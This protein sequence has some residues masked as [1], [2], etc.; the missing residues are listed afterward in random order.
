M[1]LLLLVTGTT[2]TNA[3]TFHRTSI[4]TYPRN[5]YRRSSIDRGWDND[6]YL[7]ALSSSSN[8]EETLDSANAKYQLESQSRAKARQKKFQTA[9][10]SRLDSSGDPLPVEWG[11][12][13]EAELPKR[14]PNEEGGEEA[15]GQGGQMF[16]NLLE[17]AEAA[18]AQ[19]VPTPAVPA[20]SATTAAVPET[21]Q[22]A[23]DQMAYYQLQLQAWQQQVATYTEFIAANPAAA[24]T[25]TMPPPPPPPPG[26]PATTAATPTTTTTTTPPAVPGTSAVPP[27]PTDPSQIKDP[28][29]Y[30]MKNPNRNSDAYEIANTSDVYLAQLKRDTAVRTEARA[31]GDNNTANQPF[32]ELGVKAIRGIISDEL[33]EVR[34]KQ[35]AQEEMRGL[36]PE[37]MKMIQEMQLEDQRRM[38]EQEEKDRLAI[39]RGG[40]IS[41]L[42]YREQLEEA[43]R[44][45]AAKMGGY[46]PE[47]VAPTPAAVVETLPP[48]EPAPVVEAVVPPPPTV[49]P[50]TLTPEPN[51]VPEATTP[52]PKP[53]YSLPVKDEAS[54]APVAPPSSE[55]TDEQRRLFR[56]LMGLLLKH[57]GGPGFGSGRLKPAETEKFRNTFHEVFDILRAEAGQMPMDDT[58][59]D[60]AADAEAAAAVSASGNTLV[61]DEGM[62]ACVKAA[63]NAYESTGQEELLMP[64]RNALLSAAG[65]I[66]KV[67]AEEEVENT[68]QYEAAVSAPEPTPEP[69]TT[70]VQPVVQT[71]SI[72]EPEPVPVAVAVEEEQTVAERL[73]VD[74]VGDENTEA[75]RKAYE[76]LKANAGDG[77]YG[78]KKGITEGEISHVSDVLKEMRSVLMTELETEN[79]GSSGGSSKYQQMLAKA[80]AAKK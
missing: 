67:I 19:G 25:I 17:R 1:A 35:R 56:S 32:E 34:R 69:V 74:I 70:N 77:K 52:P 13:I 63:V 57:R 61:L 14:K 47:P 30:L 54:M 79:T 15:E 7:D 66:N 46:V 24:S 49:S 16:K 41:G 59:A 45:K 4:T 5:T 28:K 40:G 6:N 23:M 29:E 36:D 2:T 26:T 33:V 72:P 53:D 21:V 51:P 43:K 12:G 76:A 80:K 68:N 11:G 27:A 55:D 42:T 22:P 75:L 20:P 58:T 37:K 60:A 62:L 9:M 71:V 73:D 38:A 3:F 39:E 18:K 64:L 48:V 44:K 78:I 10:S 65:S 31:H 50:V 8:N